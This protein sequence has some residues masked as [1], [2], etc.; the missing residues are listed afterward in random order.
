[1]SLT[2][3]VTLG[4]RSYPVRVGQN[5]LHELGGQVRHAVRSARALVV[6]N[7]LVDGLYGPT[8][9]S[10][11]EEAGYGVAKALVEDSEDSKS[12]ETAEMLYERLVLEGHERSD[13]VIALGGGVVGDLAGFVAATYMRGV[14]LVQVPTTLLAQVDSSV[15][16]KVAVNLPTGKNLI[17]AF[18]QPRLVLADIATLAS[19]DE[20]QVVAGAAEL[21]KMGLIAGGE[22]FEFLTRDLSRVLAREPESLARAVFEAVSAKAH[23]VE[24][25]ETDRGHRSVLNLGHTT[26]HALEQ[27][28]G[29]GA[30]LHGEAVA[31]GIIVATYVAE[32]MGVTDSGEAER[33]RALVRRLEVPVPVPLDVDG[34]VAQMYRDKKARSGA[35]RFVLLAKV[36]EPVIE[37]VQEAIVVSALKRLEGDA[38]TQGS[39]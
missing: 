29:Y 38:A 15:G 21:V 26:A 27:R 8:V 33:V 39:A 28:L 24:A 35:L 1:M 13:P 25:D 19:L 23:V 10:S 14:P 4:A 18:W 6:T 31:I 36:G 3:E 2:L 22:F 12:L 5:I 37:T 17:G 11:L 9:V 32:A 34:L 16:G 7:P 20:R 30:I